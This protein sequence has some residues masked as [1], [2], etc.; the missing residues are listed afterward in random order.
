VPA[1]SKSIWITVF[2]AFAACVVAP[3]LPSDASA[4]RTPFPGNHEIVADPADT[5]PPSV[6]SAAVGEVNRGDSRMCNSTS[7]HD[8]ASFT[9]ELDAS[10]DVSPREEIGFLVEVVEG[11]LPEGAMPLGGPF[12]ALGSFGYIV[13]WSET[14]NP[15]F[16]SRLSVSAVDRA[17]NV[18]EP[19]FVEVSDGAFEGCTAAPGMRG[20][21]PLAPVG[22]AIALLILGRSR[23][24]RGARLPR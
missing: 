18:S 15:A 16:F 22:L 23:S 10:D 7:C 14:S 17:G 1:R 8:M 11:E 13:R 19:T 20:T 21:L 9:L 12:Q 3:M 2:A 5:T 24:T 6:P 4:C